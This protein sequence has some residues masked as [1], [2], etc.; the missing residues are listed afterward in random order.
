MPNNNIRSWKSLSKKNRRQKKRK[1]YLQT[2]PVVSSQDDTDDTRMIDHDKELSHMAVAKRK[3]KQKRKQARRRAFHIRWLVL[4]IFLGAFASFAAGW[5]IFKVADPSAGGVSFAIEAPETA[6]PGEEIEVMFVVTN[7]E[8]VGLRN[9]ELTIQWPEDIRVISAQP[10]ARNEAQTTWDISDM[11]VRDTAIITVRIQVFGEEREVK[12]LN[13]TLVYQLANFSSD[14]FANQTHSIV[15]G[16]PVLDVVV[17]APVEVTPLVENQW[18]FSVT[19]QTEERLRAG[20]FVISAPRV[21]R[22][23]ITEPEA[24]TETDDVQT[25]LVFEVDRL[26]PGE[27]QEFVVT[28]SFAPGSQGKELLT[29]RYGFVEDDVFTVI[30]EG[31]HTTFVIGDEVEIAVQING[32]EADQI[33]KL[34]VGESITMTLQAKN[35]TEL[36]LT[37]NTWTVSLPVGSIRSSSITSDYATSFDEVSGSI[38]ITSDANESLSEI[39]PGDEIEIP[40]TFQLRDFGSNT[41]SVGVRFVTEIGEGED[42]ETASYSKDMR[43][44]PFASVAQWHTSAHY[45]NDEGV[46]VGN[47]P[48]PPV[49]DQTTTYRIQWNIVSLAQHGS[50]SIRTTLPSSVAWDNQSSAT[51]GNITYNTSS[52]TVTWVIP[53]ADVYDFSSGELQAWFDVAVTPSASQEG[54]VLALTGEHTFQISEGSTVNTLQGSALSTRL[55]GDLFGG[56]N[57][58]VIGLY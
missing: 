9:G 45:Y 8:S 5:W 39:D 57:G 44:I 54:I 53:N 49:V 13:A 58:V 38:T 15:I 7:N 2:H 18:R 40:V 41:L 32:V 11:D 37:K 28:G 50:A 35:I 12:N 24:E 17:T 46:Q 51:E 19:N 36:P 6:K 20:N 1:Q 14:F 16:D 33:E 4:F 10:E 22:E 47:G 34:N 3:Q 43:N 52:R 29:W 42:A 31:E 21:L 23:I 30:Q 26:Q 27:Q 55:E 25:L 56:G 48:H